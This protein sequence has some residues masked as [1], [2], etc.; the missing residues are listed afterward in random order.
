MR[1]R[2]FAFLAEEAQTMAEYAVTLAVITIG[3]VAALGALAL[4][5]EGRLGTVIGFL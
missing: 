1:S 4:G 2:T 3:I 5:V